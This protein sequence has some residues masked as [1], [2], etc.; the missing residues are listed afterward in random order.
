[1]NNDTTLDKS[2]KVILT[3]LVILLLA[4]FVVVGLMFVFSLFLANFESLIKIQGKD[5]I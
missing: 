3:M 1:M 5:S 4:C 2:V